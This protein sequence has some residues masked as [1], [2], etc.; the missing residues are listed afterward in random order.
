MENWRTRTGSTRLW[1]GLPV[2]TSARWARCSDP[3]PVGMRGA[4]GLAIPLGEVEAFGRF[5]RVGG[6]LSS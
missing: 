3:R 5:E 4:A 1:V 6:S 2:R